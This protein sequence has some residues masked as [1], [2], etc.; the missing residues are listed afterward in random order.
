MD[1]V[2]EKKLYEEQHLIYEYR[3]SNKEIL[4]GELR[5]KYYPEKHVVLYLVIPPFEQHCFALDAYYDFTFLNP[6]AV[7]DFYYTFCARL[8]KNNKFLDVFNKENLSCKLSTVNC[9]YS[10]FNNSDGE[11]KTTIIT[12]YTLPRQSYGSFQDELLSALSLY[13]KRSPDMG[14]LKIKTVLIQRD[15]NRL[16]DIDWLFKI[17]KRKK[18]GMTKINFLSKNWRRLYG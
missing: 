2:K 9:H 5:I 8:N 3:K 7:D 11:L 6:L 4:Q 1:L 17:L 16:T 12:D 15:R 14:W 18:R 10:I 13:E